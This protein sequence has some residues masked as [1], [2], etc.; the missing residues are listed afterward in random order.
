MTWY[1]SQIMTTGAP[2]ILAASERNP[3][4]V[5]HVFHVTNP[6]H[7]DWYTPDVKHSVPNDGLVFIRPICDPADPSAEWHGDDLLSWERFANTSGADVILTPQVLAERR[8]EL[9][10][11]GFA[12][13]DILRI[14]KKLNTDT[15]VPV[16]FYYCFCWGG[17]VEFEYA[18]I[19]DKS[20]RVLIRQIEDVPP[21]I[22]RL[23]E[24]DADTEIIR[25]EDVL[26]RMLRSLSC[27]LPTRYF[28]PHTRGFPWHE[29]RLGR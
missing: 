11:A 21:D 17:D 8:S 20:E 1:A 18:W 29:H 19:F 2:S 4:F 7:H 9:N 6:I 5:D 28:A 27:E 23:L 26:V 22:N 10:A 12:A 16:A 24:I 14:A 15:N 25:D 3:A 13:A